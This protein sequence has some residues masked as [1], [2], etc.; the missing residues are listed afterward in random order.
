MTKQ[1]TKLSSVNVPEGFYE[2]FL[3]TVPRG[4]SSVVDKLHDLEPRARGRGLSRVLKDITEAEWNDLYQRAAA[5]RAAMKGDSRGANRDTTLGPAIAAGTLATRM[6]RQGVANPV[7]YT[8][9]KTTRRTKA[10]IMAARAEEAQVASVVD[11][12]K[13]VEPE[14]PSDPPVLEQVN[15]PEATPSEQQAFQK[16]MALG[17]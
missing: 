14:V 6:E 13:A 1:R 5:G 3:S 15:V 11:A 17:K 9:K 4:T 16:D 8:P 2:R 7:P 10:E 12:L